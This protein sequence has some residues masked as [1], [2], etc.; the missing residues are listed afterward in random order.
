MAII[1]NEI[2]GFFKNSAVNV[3]GGAV[4]SFL[5]FLFNFVV[6]KFISKENYGEY[7]SAMAYVTLL[8]APL[9]ILSLI[10]IKK[11][12]SQLAETRAK[13]L[14]RMNAGL[15]QLIK[16]N[17][18]WLILMMP[19]LWWWLQSGAGFESSWSPI[20][21]LA[22]IVLMSIVNWLTALIAGL[23]MFTILSLASIAAMGIRF[24]LGWAALSLND[25]LIIL[26]LMI[27]IITLGQ[28]LIYKMALKN[29]IKIKL[30]GREKIKIEWWQ[31]VKKDDL[32]IPLAATLVTTGLINLDMIVIKKVTEA[33]FAGEYGVF[34]LFAKILFYAS[35]PLVNVAFTFFN[36]VKDRKE[37][38][39]IFFISTGLI[40]SL[41]ILMVGLYAWWPEFL[42]T[43]VSDKKYLSLAPVLFMAAIFGGLYSFIMLLVQFLIAKNNR[44]VFLGLL[45]PI[46]QAGLIYF[47]HQEMSQIMLIN[48]GVASALILIFMIGKLKNA[49]KTV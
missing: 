34:S 8:T 1:S 19:V 41:T 4:A 39:K 10:I 32:L 2:K 33:D 25:T 31:Y 12:S 9:S 20:L 49:Q 42:I 28:I 24:I 27:I 47:Y 30:L 7:V 40:A 13:Y 35:L 22:M 6:V 43:G 23:Q 3:I 15:W 36:S 48:I 29:K 14:Q 46:I 37:R 16:K 11:I 18:Y 5:S 45:A 38:N 26:Y 17:I 44:L 21:V